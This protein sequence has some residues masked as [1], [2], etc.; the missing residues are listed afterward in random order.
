[1]QCPSN[2]KRK[3]YDPF[4]TYQNIA[5]NINRFRELNVIPIDSL[6]LSKEKCT[7]DLFLTMKAKFHKLCRNKFSDMKSQRIEQR[8][9]TIEIEPQPED[10][11]NVD[12]KITEEETISQATQSSTRPSASKDAVENDDLLC[13]FCGKGKPQ[14]LRRASTFK[15][16]KKVRECAMT[17]QDFDLL[18]KLSEGDMIAQD[19]M[20]HPLCLL[21]FF[22]KAK[23]VNDHS[24]PIVDEE[25]E[26]HGMVLAEMLVFMQLERDRLGGN[27]V[28]K[29]ADLAALY[30]K[31]FEDLGGVMPERVHST[32][33]KFRLYA[34]TDGLMESKRGKTTYLAFD[35][36]LCD[37]FKTIY[38]K[39]FDEDAFVLSRAADILCKSLLE[40]ESKEFD[41]KFILIHNHHSFRKCYR[42]L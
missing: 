28:F 31:R 4:K 27:C 36:D 37:I 10:E 29:M 21:V 16:D 18:A 15:L 17:L 24:A 5:N 40:R 1:M 6:I 9:N 14:N 13:F 3:G 20:Y 2:L 38:E 32:R 39:D 35:D 34:H 25:K 8:I 41:G 19:A 22:K 12:C 26:L 33:L 42:R 23:S 30:K 11:Q 7:P